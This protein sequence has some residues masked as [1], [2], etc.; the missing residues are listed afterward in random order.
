LASNKRKNAVEADNAAILARWNAPG[1]AG[2]FAWLEDVKPRILLASNKYGEFALEPWQRSILADALAVDDAG[3]FVHSLA[4]TRMPRRHSK[5][6][7]WAL[8]VLWLATS[9]ENWTVTLLGNSEEHSTRTQFKPL[10]RIIAHTKS[11][12]AMIPP[13]SIL[14]FSISV[15]HT[16]STIQ[17]GAS[18]MSTAFGDRVNV[19]WASDF[20]QVDQAVFDALSGS[21]LDS[22]GTLTLID[23]NADPEG[24]PV[25]ALEQLAATDPQIFCRAVEYENFEDYCDRAPA[26]IDRG[27]ARQLQRTQL[28]TAFA[29]DIL[30][31]R[32]AAKNALFP[33]ETIA[34]CRAEIPHP[35]PP[36]HLQE[37][38]AGRRYVVGMGLDRSKR[39]FGGD[40]TVLTSC[41][42]LSSESG[43]PEYYI[44]HQ[45]KIEPNAAVFIKRAI[46]KD[47]Q[48]Y[49]IDNLVLEDYETADLRPWVQEQKIPCESLSA[50]SKN[51]NL[52]FIE[53]HRIAREG[54][55]HF[56]ASMDDLQ[57][58]MGTFIYQELRDGMYSFG[59][60][61]QKFHDDRV[62]SLNWSVF[63]T[64]ANVLELYALPR[65]ICNNKSPR[66]GLCFLWGGDMELLCKHECQAFHDVDKMFRSFMRL[67]TEED[68]TLPGFYAAYVKV[69]GPKVYQGV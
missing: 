8:V 33:P 49:K 61:S 22:Q 56:C 17:G 32:S 52:S 4:L 63:A 35:F 11:L 30:G 44:L 9:R 38:V 40:A 47:H 54:R 27:K 19:L 41:L 58:E 18:G 67:R 65:L 43:E 59:H 24:G 1:A 51:Q 60:S 69:T 36:D 29:R 15:P 37:L 62:Y 25:H 66:R 16:D 42:K 34:L 12:T 48:T 28:E 64:R 45:Q 2:F 6:T 55:L 10:K 57:S 14:K 50:H 46:V 53:L 26:W 20:H 31:K 7:L 21:L 5:S 3:L 13:E 39:L 23:A 68:M